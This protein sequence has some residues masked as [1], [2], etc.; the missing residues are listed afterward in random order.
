MT[1]I[2]EW[3][4]TQFDMKDL[5]EAAY[6]L[7]IQIIRNRKNR[8]L[9]LSQTTYIDKVLERFSMNNTIGANMPSRYGI[10]LSKEQSPTDP[11]EIEDMAKIPYA[12]AVGSLMYAMLCTRPDICYAVGIVSRYQ[13]NPGQEHWNAVKYILKYLKSTRNLVLVYKG[14]ALNPIGYTDSDFQASLEDRKSTSGMVFTLGGGA[15]VWRSAKQT[16][17]SDSTM[18]AEYIAAAEAAKE[19][20]WLRKFFTSIGVVPGMEKPLVLLCDNNGAIANSKEPRSHKRSKHIERKYHII[21]EYVARGDVL[22]EKVD[23]EDNLADPFTK[24][25]AVT[26]FEKHRQN[27]GLIDMY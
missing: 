12:S 23:T 18:E 9:A 8:S 16:A 4:N 21:R 22:V 19:L 25:L 17:I 15:V 14:G 5:G 24:V 20:V 26:A 10:R 3:L 2:K 6:V 11:Q 27:L 1:H 13:S 7:G